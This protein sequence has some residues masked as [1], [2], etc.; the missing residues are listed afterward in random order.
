MADVK[1]SALTELPG[2]DIVADDVLPIVDTSATT[3]KKV[4]FSELQSTLSGFT[5]LLWGLETSNNATDATNDIDVA[6]GRARDDG[7]SDMMVLAS[8]ITK[9]IDAAWVVGT[10]QGGM[11]TGSVAN[12][13]WYFVWLIKRSDTGVVDVLF[14]LSSTAPTM[15]ANYDLKRLIGAVRRD[16]ATNRKFYQSGNMFTYQAQVNVLSSG[17][18]TSA[19][20][21]TL[22]AAIPTNT[23]IFKIVCRTLNNHA[24]VG[25]SYNELRVRIATGVDFATVIGGADGSGAGQTTLFCS[26]ALI[27]NTG[28]FQYYN[29]QQGTGQEGSNSSIWVTGFIFPREIL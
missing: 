4:Q 15:P 12:D 3:T 23:S 1:I 9:R 24:N 26:E 14:S 28:V 19:T 21:I 11:D 25:E 20:S 13:T 27:P 5:D 29:V 6:I 22:T 17:S 7:D 18:A 8:S 10:N 2:A 16:T